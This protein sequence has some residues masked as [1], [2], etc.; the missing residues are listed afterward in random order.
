MWEIMLRKQRVIGTYETCTGAK[1]S[2]NRDVVQ[3]IDDGLKPFDQFG[4][5]F[6]EFVESFG[7][8]VEYVKNCFS[9]IACFDL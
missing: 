8:Y 5:T 3:A 2:A 6:R 9:G 4:A 7:L 1:G